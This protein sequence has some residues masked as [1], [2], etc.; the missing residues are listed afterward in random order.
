MKPHEKS[1]VCGGGA[2]KE[3]PARSR[4]ESYADGGNGGVVRRRTESYG[5]ARSRTGSH[6]VARSRPESHGVARSRTEPHGAAR[7][8]TEPHGAARSRTERDD[9]AW[10]LWQP[11]AG[12][13]SACFWGCEARAGAHQQDAAQRP[14]AG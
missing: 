9:V 6:G 4:T 14:A 7:S 12:E 8:R 10:N 3:G 11:E 1:W 5:V 13:A 2:K